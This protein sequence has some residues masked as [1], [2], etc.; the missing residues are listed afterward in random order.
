MPQHDLEQRVANLEQKMVFVVTRDEL[1]EVIR[2]LHMRFDRIENRF[3]AL[4]NG[5][6]GN[7]VRLDS[8]SSQFSSF[9]DE[10]RR[11]NDASGKAWEKLDGH[12]TM[13]DE[14]RGQLFRKMAAIQTALENRGI[15]V[16]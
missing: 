5:V 16:D 13:A 14:D 8:F 11:A 12:M 10:Q 9:R 3:D 15:S 6:D 2:S 1:A 4:E 7:G